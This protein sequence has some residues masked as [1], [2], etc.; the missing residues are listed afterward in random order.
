[1]RCITQTIYNEGR[2]YA[3]KQSAQTVYKANIDFRYYR[4]EPYNLQHTANDVISI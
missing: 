3:H 4:T 2:T 1:M